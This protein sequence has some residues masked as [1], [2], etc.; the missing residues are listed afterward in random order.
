[1]ITKK[2]TPYVG[3]SINKEDGIIFPEFHTTHQTTDFFLLYG[4][5]GGVQ[6]LIL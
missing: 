4:G 5:G 1:M 6:Y 2:F 3:T